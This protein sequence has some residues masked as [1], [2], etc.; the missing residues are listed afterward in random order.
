MENEKDYIVKVH[1]H[2]GGKPILKTGEIVSL[3][4]DEAKDLLEIGAIREM[5]G[6]LKAGHQNTDEATQKIIDGYKDDL[7]N[8]E[9]RLESL[10]QDIDKKNKLIKKLKNGNRGG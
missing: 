6:S 4:D 9:K 10:E 1:V 7:S 8:A 3:S 5:S 2:R